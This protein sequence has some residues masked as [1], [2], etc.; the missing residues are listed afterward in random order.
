VKSFCTAALILAGLVPGAWA[1]VRVEIVL[2]QDQFL[3]G[4]TLRA[5]V[6]IANRS[7]QTLNLGS[8]P[9]WLSFAFESRD[10]F[11]IVKESDPPVMGEFSL[12]SAEVGTKWVNLAP[13]YNLTQPG[14]YTVTATVRIKQWNDQVVSDG[15][16]FDIISGAKLWS[17]DFG[18]PPPPGVTNVAP[19][20]RRYTL[21]Q[22]NYLRKQVKIYVRLTDVTEAKVFKVFPVG[23][24]PAFNQ[25]EPQL[26]KFSDLHLLYQVG[27]KTFSYTVVNP[28]GDIILRQTYD[29]VN[30]RPRLQ[31]DKQ[32]RLVVIGG[33][34]HPTVNDVPPPAPPKG[35]ATPAKGK[36]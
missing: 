35:T 15:K 16:S 17:Q 3:A 5:G 14:H 36:S 1:Q 7:G 20:M 22:A 30:S 23:P 4:E 24:L 32:G 29:Y 11:P 6:R 12:E 25:V 10:D 13:H 27:A 26:D 34:R 9:D 21:E 2:D 8:E 18:V 28:D 33:V 19:E 31:P